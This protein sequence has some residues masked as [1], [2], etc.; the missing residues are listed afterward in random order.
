MLNLGT[1]LRSA[2]QGMVAANTAH[3]GQLARIVAL[4]DQRDSLSQGLLGRFLKARHGLEGLF[5]TR[6]GFPMLAVAGDTPRDPTGLVHQVRETVD[7]LRQPKVERPSLDLAGFQIDLVATATQL[8]GEA[9]ELDGVLAHLERAR[10]DADV[11]RQAKNDAI[12]RYDSIFLWVARALESYF[13]L[14]GMHE[15]AERVRPSAR[16]PGRQPA[17]D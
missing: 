17:G 7:F 13:H 9:D 11:T 10:K 12:D 8:G 5:G 3:V 15:L 16:R 1:E 4:Q 6:Q 2:Q 14:A